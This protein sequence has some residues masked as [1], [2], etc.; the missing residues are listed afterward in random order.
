MTELPLSNFETLLYACRHQADKQA[1]ADKGLHAKS[2]NQ[3]IMH[4]RRK[5]GGKAGGRL[6]AVGTVVYHQAINTARGQGN[7][8]ALRQHEGL[9]PNVLNEAVDECLQPYTY[10]H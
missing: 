8:E 7:G 2:R 4:D 5:Q 10:F 3:A 6:K 1:R 9:Q